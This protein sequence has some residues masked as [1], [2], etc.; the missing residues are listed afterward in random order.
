MKL[1]R[2][3]FI[4]E[5]LGIILDPPL[6]LCESVEKAKRGIEFLHPSINWDI[7]TETTDSTYAEF[8]NCIEGYFLTTPHGATLDDLKTTWR[9]YWQSLL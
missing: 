8:V 6:T 9:R 1:T 2:C 4:H 5:R 7:H 3:C